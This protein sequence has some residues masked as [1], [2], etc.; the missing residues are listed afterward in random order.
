MRPV[1]DLTTAEGEAMT[2]PEATHE[3]FAYY[4]HDDSAEPLEMTDPEPVVIDGDKLRDAYSRVVGIKSD[5]EWV[6]PEG[7]TRLLVRAL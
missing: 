1:L 7:N 5:S 6:M 3:I 4:P 2:Q